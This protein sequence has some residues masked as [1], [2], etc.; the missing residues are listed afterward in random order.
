MPCDVCRGWNHPQRLS[1]APSPPPHL[2]RVHHHVRRQPDGVVRLL[3]LAHRGAA[4]TLQVEQ[5]HSAGEGHSVLAV[6]RESVR[7]RPVR[8]ASL[9]QA[10]LRRKTSG[11]TLSLRS[12][13]CT[14]AVFPVHTQKWDTHWGY[15]YVCVVTWLD[16]VRLDRPW[17]TAAASVPRWLQGSD[18]ATGWWTPPASKSGCHSCTGKGKKH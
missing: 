9:T 15:V 3:Q 8:R 16:E 13:T 4:E 10:E 7:I 18:P 11:P 12:C 14:P 1:S 2:P 17:G 5:Q 6:V